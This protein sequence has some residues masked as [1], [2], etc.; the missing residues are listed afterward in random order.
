E[1]PRLLE[2]ILNG[3]ADVVF[4]SRFAGGEL[5]RVRPSGNSLVSQ[6][7]IEINLHIS[8]RFR[9]GLHGLDYAD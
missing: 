4:G 5:H 1:Y 6:N 3:K 2:P 7:E 8:G 9:L